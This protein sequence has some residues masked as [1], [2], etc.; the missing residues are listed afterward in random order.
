MVDN[1]N[2]RGY[3][4][5]TSMIHS[6]GICCTV[7]TILRMYVLKDYSVTT[8]IPRLVILL[9]LDVLI[10][11]YNISARKGTTSYGRIL[12]TPYRKSISLSRYACTFGPGCIFPN[13]GPVYVK[14]TQRKTPYP[15]Y[16]RCCIAYVK[17]FNHMIYDSVCTQYYWGK[18]EI[19]TW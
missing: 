3:V 6:K 13:H 1:R 19:Y 12:C 4:H 17:A 10:T 8:G 9:T 7:I 18:H 15:V 2:V 5:L 16:T 14:V 11:T